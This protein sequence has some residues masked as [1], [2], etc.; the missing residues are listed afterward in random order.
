MKRPAANSGG[1]VKMAPLSRGFH[2]I[3]D[4]RFV[5][6]QRTQNRSCKTGQE[7]SIDSSFIRIR[8]QL[9]HLK[10]FKVMPWI[11]AADGTSIIR[12][13]HRCRFIS[14]LMN[15]FI[16]EKGRMR[17]KQ[18]ASTQSPA[19]ALRRRNGKDSAR[20]ENDPRAPP[21]IQV[22]SVGLWVHFKATMVTSGGRHSRTSAGSGALRS[23]A[24]VHAAPGENQFPLARH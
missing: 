5:R 24:E 9:R 21:T 2:E 4:E 20:W 16:A 23:G 13:I 3:A 22:P 12:S 8:P 11:K 14:G 6:S 1:R 15:S 18:P 7:L 10:S 17:R 19:D